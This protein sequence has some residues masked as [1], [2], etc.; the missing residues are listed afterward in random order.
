MNT[1]TGFLLCCAGELSQSGLGSP[2]VCVCCVQGED[3]YHMGS[4]NT[5]KSE[6][7]IV[8]EVFKW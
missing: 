1:P 7:L 6:Q 2:R 8:Q 4:V 5:V 3:K